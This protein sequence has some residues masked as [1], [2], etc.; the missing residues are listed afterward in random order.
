VT[1]A[2]ELPDLHG[3]FQ[4]LPEIVGD[5]KCDR[6]EA[7]NLLGPHSVKSA[8]R[9]YLDKLDTVAPAATSRVVD[10]MPDNLNH[11]G[12][13]ALLFP[14]AKVIICRRDPRD[15]A[16]SCW[17]TGFRPCP[18]NN[19]YDHIA[20]RLAD[21]QRILAHWRQV[22]PLHFIEL[23]YEELVADLERHARLLI[24]FVGLEWDP[25]C[26]EFHTNPR[27]VRSP[28]LAQVRRPIHSRSAGRWRNYESYVQPLFHALA[29][30][31][32]EIPNH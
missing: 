7:I 13:I 24:D 29:R 11:L 28:S 16:V 2:G 22:K 27:V 31:G 4:S 26:L 8:A 23:P 19:D 25:S 10:K 1:G 30:H 32:V 3:V 9:R 12:L 21:F 5:S 14:R 15:I 18:W 17:Q 20:R 6:F